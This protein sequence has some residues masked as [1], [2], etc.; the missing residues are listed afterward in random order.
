MNF[1]NLLSMPENI[2]EHLKRMFT[3]ID[4]KGK[5]VIIEIDFAGSET[6]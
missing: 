2:M 5:N 1:L 4:F 6:D 3:R